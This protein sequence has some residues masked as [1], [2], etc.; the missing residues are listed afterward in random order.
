MRVEV[1]SDMVCPWCY[2]GKRRLEAA[3][4]RF[5]HRKQTQVLWRSFELNPDAPAHHDGGLDDLL[6]RKYGMN[7]LQ[8]RAVNTRLTDLAAAEGLE[9]HLESA[10]PGNTFTAHRLLHLAA[11][12]GLQ[13]ALQERIFR[14]YFTEGA[15]IGDPETLVRL[16]A[17]AGVDPAE[18]RAVATGSAYADGV[19]AEEQEAVDL[20][21]EGVPFFVIDRAYAVAGAQSAD[22]LLEALRRAWADQRSEPEVEDPATD[23]DDGHCTGGNCTL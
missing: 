2:I 10:R 9:Y 3:L 14:G 22:V 21:C 7:R 17:E 23:P 11:A 13:P 6:A 4:R 18:A 15:A 5:D 19:R 16:A 8:A 20:G 1:W 12:R